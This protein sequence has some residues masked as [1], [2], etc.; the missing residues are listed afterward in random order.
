MSIM[1]RGEPHGS[2][3]FSPRGTFHAWFKEVRD[4]CRRSRHEAWNADDKMLLLREIESL[5]K[6]LGEYRV[7]LKRDLSTPGVD[8]GRP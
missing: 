1:A 7:L 8:D 6:I 4:L 3:P 2:P 5:E